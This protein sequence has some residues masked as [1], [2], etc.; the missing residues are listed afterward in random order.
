[1]KLAI[2]LALAS[3][4]ARAEPK[5]ATARVERLADG[6]FAI[7][8]DPATDYWSHSN[9]GVVIGSDAVLVIDATYL[10]SRARA[11][12]AL[13]RA[14]TPKPVRY[15]AFTHW[16]DDHTNGAIAYRD[17]F[18]G[19]TIVAE[20]EMARFIELTGP[21]HAAQAVR[22][23]SDER[24]RIAELEAMLAG[25]KDDHG[26]PLDDA[27]KRTF[28]RQLAQRRGELAELASFKVAPAN[29]RF[30]QRMTL[31]LGGKRVE[32]RNWGH[33]NSP[34]DVTFWLPAE[35]VLF[36]GD[37]LVQDPF[38]YYSNSWPVPWL[39]VLEQLEQLPTA[40]IVPG[41]GPVFHDQTYLRLVHE[42]M[43]TI[44]ARVEDMT[45]AGKSVDEM[46]AA[47]DG[48]DLRARW[49]A[50]TPAEGRALWKR[51]IDRLIER[52]WRGVQGQG[53]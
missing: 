49:P 27:A 26:A 36:T 29:L 44:V 39:A 30:V 41:H 18:P 37:V 50:W 11:D 24:K 8:H 35:R 7:V 47:I 23:D 32:L 40:A 12:I 10:P 14:L 17:A 16:H 34:D 25:G 53:G 9:T 3:S 33:A 5:D 28:A 43:K 19:I 48:E 20:E 22:A 38:P 42:V 52:A 51:G 13:I 21:K 4:I 1:M 6:V 46:R 15:L 31:D 2:A 45:R